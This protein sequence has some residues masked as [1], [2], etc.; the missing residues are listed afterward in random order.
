M[1]FEKLT[2]RILVQGDYAACCDFYTEKLG[3]E[4]KWGDRNGPYT[5][6]GVPGGQP[7]FAIFNAAEMAALDTYTPSPKTAQPSQDRVVCVVPSDDLQA[8]YLRLKENGVEF[9]GEPQR[10]EGWG[11]SLVCFRDPEGNLFELN[12]AEG[13]V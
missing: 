3:L 5:S 8:D 13:G 7:C 4:I 10:V 2:A 9:M 6:F 12:D 11:M 1:N